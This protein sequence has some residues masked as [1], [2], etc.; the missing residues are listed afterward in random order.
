[1]TTTRSFFDS[2][3]RH[4]TGLV[5]GLVL[6]IVAGVTLQFFLDRRTEKEGTAQNALFLA[7]SLVEKTTAD[8]EKAQTP[9]PVAPSTKSKTPQAP[10]AKPSIEFSK[11]DVAQVYGT[12]ITA[13]DK[14][15]VEHPGTHAGF[16]AQLQIADLYFNHGDPVRSIEF[17]KKAIATGAK[18]GE[19]ASAHLSLGYAYENA[20]QNAEALKA[21]ETAISTFDSQPASQALLPDALL[22][23]A[24]V[25]ELLQQGA[26]AKGV[27]EKVIKQFP[28][29]EA[30]KTA[31]AQKAKL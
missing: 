29:S 4:T 21:I 9:P 5:A 31:E 30:A 7:Q 22:A 20:G 23:Q 19:L 12:A 3:S 17:Y 24:R 14:V 15:A 2:L 16:L 6:L 10:P 13:L 25:H 26:Q 1:M 11:L 8:L 18:K 28:N 27:Y